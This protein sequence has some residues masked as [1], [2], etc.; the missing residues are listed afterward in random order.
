MLCSK[1]NWSLRPFL[2]VFNKVIIHLQKKKKKSKKSECL[3]IPIK[4]AA[5]P[6]VRKFD[7]Q[8]VGYLVSPGDVVYIRRGALARTHDTNEPQSNL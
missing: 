1:K 7:H 3:N 4:A 2:N 8:A 6:A 5:D